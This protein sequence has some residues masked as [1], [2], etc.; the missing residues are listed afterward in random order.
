M[1]S[2]KNLLVSFMAIFAVISLLSCVSALDVSIDKVEINDQ[3]LDGST[4][5]VFAGES[6]PVK[7]FFTA[8]ENAPDIRVKAWISGYRDA[9]EAV[10]ERIRLLNGSSYAKTLLLEVPADLDLSEKHSLYIRME[11]NTDFVEKQY[12]LVMQRESYTAELLQVEGSETVKAGSEM[13]ITLVLKNK[14]YEEL[15]DLKVSAKILET[16]DA[17][18]AYLGDL[19]AVDSDEKE[20][21][22][23]K[24]VVL[25][26]PSN[27]ESGIYTLEVKVSNADFES[28]VVKKITVYGLRDTTRVLVA[29]KDQV[30]KTGESGEWNFEIVNLGKETRVYEIVPETSEKFAA[31]VSPS[32]V[33]VRE[34]ESKSIKVEASAENEGVYN[35]AVR[36]T[37]EGKLV[38]K[39]LLSAKVEKGFFD[40]STILAIALAVVFAVLLIVLIVLLTRKPKKADELEESYY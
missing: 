18:N 24:S 30:F 16:G 17:V 11:D 22:I 7:V 27:L 39:M 31:R 32:T 40:S 3:V 23:E 4:V 34:G 6:L 8:H 5:A 1:K 13:E 25:R 12:T 15:E 33:I 36:I 28:K 37:S 38:G 19:P 26:I 35:F 29:G 9:I 14:G 2:I 20:D 10:S 21:T